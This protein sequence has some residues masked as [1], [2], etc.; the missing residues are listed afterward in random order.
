MEETTCFNHICRYPVANLGPVPEVRRHAERCR[1]I[2]LEEMLFH[3][4]RATLEA[5]SRR[6]CVLLALSPL[7]AWCSPGQQEL[8]H[9]AFSRNRTRASA[10]MGKELWLVVV[11]CDR[12]LA[13]QNNTESM[14]ALLFPAYA[15]LETYVS[16][17]A[18]IRK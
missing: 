6:S 9:L 13:C 18:C 5:H 14:A 15:C 2:P 1:L 12:D 8:E 17:A 16:N 11:L 4:M 7:L 3:R 10:S